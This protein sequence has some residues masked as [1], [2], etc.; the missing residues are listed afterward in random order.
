MLLVTNLTNTKICEKRKT[1]KPWHMCTHLR[2][3]SEN[4]PMNTNMT[5]FKWFSE[6]FASLYFASIGRVKIMKPP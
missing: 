1:L 6:I 2:V 3:L 5:R 4:Y